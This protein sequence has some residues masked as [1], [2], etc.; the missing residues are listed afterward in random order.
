MCFLSSLKKVFTQAAVSFSSSSV[1]Q[2][3][4]WLFHKKMKTVPR[5]V[6][7][8]DTPC[9]SWCFRKEMGLQ[10]HL[11]N[12]AFWRRRH[13]NFWSPHSSASPACYTSA[14]PSHLLFRVILRGCVFALVTFPSGGLENYSL[15]GT[16]PSTSVS[17]VWSPLREADGVC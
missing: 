8:P 10:V 3:Q 5:A 4:S 7:S 14:S 11:C 16:A 9:L 2:S 12:Q 17:I 15:F 6:A 13:L 1:L